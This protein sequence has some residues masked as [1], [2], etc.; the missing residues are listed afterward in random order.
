MKFIKLIFFISVLVFFCTFLT[1]LIR[2]KNQ[3]RF[4][5]ELLSLVSVVN[6]ESKVGTPN[7]VFNSY[8]GW[9]GKE[10][11]TKK[12]FEAGLTIRVYLV[13]KIPPRFLIL[14]VS[15]DGMTIVDSDIEKS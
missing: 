12:E 4:E 10:L 1:L 3:L 9:F 13:Q 15:P 11:I 14:K 8:G 5:T 6:V 7:Y 2:H